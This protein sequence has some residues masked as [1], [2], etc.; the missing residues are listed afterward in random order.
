MDRAGNVYVADVDNHAI[1]VLQPVAAAPLPNITA[2]GITNAATAL[3]GAIA[4][5]EFI[6]IWGRGLGPDSGGYSGPMTT[7]AA[8]TSVYIGGIPAA[9][10]YSSAAQVNAVVPFGIA[11]RGATTIQVEYNGVQGNVITVPVVASSPGIL[12]REAA[13]GRLWVVNQDLTFNSAS[14]P[15]AR[16][17]YVS[18]LG[19]RP[20]PRRCPAAGW[21][22]AHRAAFSNPAAAGEC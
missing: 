18:I 22:P 10:V 8:G 5:N 3:A 13:R 19:D 21:R 15:A 16:D 17:S 20:G 2:A 4:P 11:Y 14:N 6:S 1:R 9:I 12:P 7:L